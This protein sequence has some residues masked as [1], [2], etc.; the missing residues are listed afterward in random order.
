MS[1]KPS[2]LDN[3]IDYSFKNSNVWVQMKTWDA[4]AMRELEKSVKEYAASHPS[5]SQSLPQDPRTL[6]SYGTTRFFMT[7]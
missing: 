7:C 4:G 1:A 3:V 5:P 2:D 6:T